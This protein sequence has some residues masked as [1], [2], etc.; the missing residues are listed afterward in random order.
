ML[1]VGRDNVWA[2]EAWRV[3]CRVDTTTLLE[4]EIKNH[5]TSLVVYLGNI[6]V[7][8]VSFISFAVPMFSHVVFTWVVQSVARLSK[9]MTR[10]CASRNQLCVK[11]YQSAR[12]SAPF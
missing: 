1:P 3:F 5:I 11:S 4:S 2:E 7:T 10:T 8:M 6:A 12:F 9:K